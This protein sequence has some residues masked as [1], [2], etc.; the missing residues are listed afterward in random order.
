MLGVF[1]V[2]A[3][4]MCTAISSRATVPRIPP[5]VLK[6]GYLILG[7]LAP[8]F[9]SHWREIAVLNQ[10]QK[11]TYSCNL[12][13]YIWPLLLSLSQMWPSSVEHAFQTICKNESDRNH[14]DDEATTTT[15][16]TTTTKEKRKKKKQAVLTKVDH[17]EIYF[18][19]SHLAKSDDIKAYIRRSQAPVNPW[20]SKKLLPITA[21]QFAGSG[22]CIAKCMTRLRVLNR[23]KT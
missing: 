4:Q 9:L 12:P 19:I 15:T 1:V 11:R 3:D 6:A 13:Q 2:Y 8:C 22:L 18:I 17:N 7:N 20:V 16:T 14:N 5:T 23:V 10:R 21:G